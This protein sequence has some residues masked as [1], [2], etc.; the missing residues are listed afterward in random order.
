MMGQGRRRKT[1]PSEPGGCFVTKSCMAPLMP[2]DRLRI[3]NVNERFSL[4][5]VILE[6]LDRVE[7]AGP[8]S[9]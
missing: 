7:A 8:P 5:P 4:E 2:G 9:G 3:A 6:M 1:L